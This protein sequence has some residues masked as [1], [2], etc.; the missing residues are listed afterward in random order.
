MDMTLSQFPIEVFRGTD[1]FSFLFLGTF[2]FET[3]PPCFEEAQASLWRSP[4]G[5]EPIVISTLRVQSFAQVTK[6]SASTGNTGKY[7]FVC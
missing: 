1:S 2:T 6:L 5:G 4:R 7:S 3:R